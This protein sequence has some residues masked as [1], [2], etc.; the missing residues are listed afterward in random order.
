MNPVGRWFDREFDYSVPQELLPNVMVRLR[1]AAARLEE[2][3][4]GGSREVLIRRPGDK[5]S[6]REYAGHLLDL[7]P[8]WL[9]RVDDFAAG[10]VQLTAADLT[11]RKTHEANHNASEA[12]GI[13]RAFRNAR[14]GLLNRVE[15]LEEATFVRVIPHPRLK[16][17]MRLID[18]LHFVSEHD[19]HHLAQMWELIKTS[20]RLGA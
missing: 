5:W 15:G 3:L 8:L 14:N 13:L 17:P 19:D 16:S 7:E 18:H 20:N 11:N 10:R 9:A 1:G 2:T 6:A 4:G 12:A